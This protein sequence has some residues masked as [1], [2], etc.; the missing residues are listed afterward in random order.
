ME[1][2]PRTV[3][4]P[5]LCLPL[6]ERLPEHVGQ[7]TD[8][9]V[10]LDARGLLMPDRSDA[11]LTLVNAKCRLGLPQVHV[12]LPHRL[13]RPVPHDGATDVAARTLARGLVPLRPPAHA[14]ADPP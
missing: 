10:R 13:G 7:E 3:A 2:R 6:L 8:E 11:E 4:E 14:H 9:D 5:G 1:D 12:R